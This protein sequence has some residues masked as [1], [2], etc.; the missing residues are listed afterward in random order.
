MCKITT[1]KRWVSE[2]MNDYCPQRNGDTSILLAN[3]AI[4]WVEPWL[5]GCQ[6]GTLTAKP[7]VH[8]NLRSRLIIVI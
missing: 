7:S 5:G 1:A 8:N 6:T 3:A 2:F 4:H